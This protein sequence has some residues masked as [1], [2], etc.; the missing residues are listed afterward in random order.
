MSRFEVEECEGGYVVRNTQT[1]IIEYRSLRYQ[2][3]MWMAKHLAE[4]A[5]AKKAQLEAQPS[6]ACDCARLRAALER[7]ARESGEPHVLRLVNEA[8]D[9]TGGEHV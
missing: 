7:V 9:T 4:E 6:A 2:G 8:L 5:N 1:D 3:A